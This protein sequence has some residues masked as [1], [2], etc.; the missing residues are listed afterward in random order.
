MMRTYQVAQIGLGVAE[1]DERFGLAD[2]WASHHFQIEQSML[3]DFV[4]GTEDS[5]DVAG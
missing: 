4:S 2:I 5:F 1:H 3:V